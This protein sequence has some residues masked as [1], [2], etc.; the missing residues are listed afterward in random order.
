[1]V[2]AVGIEVAKQLYF[3]WGNGIFMLAGLISG[4]TGALMI[5]AFMKRAQ[6]A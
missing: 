5:T 4:L 1:V 3:A 6:K 2:F